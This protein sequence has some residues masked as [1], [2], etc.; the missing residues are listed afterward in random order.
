MTQSW[1][2]IPGLVPVVRTTPH[3]WAIWVIWNGSH[4]PIHGEV[5]QGSLNAT[6][7]WGDHFQCFWRHEL[8]GPWASSWNLKIDENC[9]MVKVQSWPQP[10][11]RPIFFQLGGRRL[12]GLPKIAHMLVLSICA[13]QE[14]SALPLVS[15]TD[16]AGDGAGNAPRCAQCLGFFCDFALRRADI[17]WNMFAWL[18]NTQVFKPSVFAKLD[19]FK[20]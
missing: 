17:G 2:I 13:S 6:T 1:R 8:F 18:L 5:L 10:T 16:G 12:T 15:R 14:Y 9:G 19:C 11:V 20:R 3:L 4:N 7:F